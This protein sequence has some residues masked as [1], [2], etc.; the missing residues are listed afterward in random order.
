MP[1]TLEQWL[2]MGIEK[3]FCTPTY[4][5]QHDSYHQEDADV[6]SELFEFS[7]GDHCM[8]VV[9]IKT[10][11]LHDQLEHYQQEE[12]EE[13]RSIERETQKDF[14]QRGPQ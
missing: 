1:L 2:E 10:S 13:R 6:L 8:T 14:L 4:C 7:G 9:R 11:E 5:D 3:G 12:V